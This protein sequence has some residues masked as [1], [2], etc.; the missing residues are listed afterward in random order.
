MTN[1]MIMRSAR[2]LSALALVFAGEQATAGTAVTITFSGVPC[3]SSTGNFSGSFIYDQGQP[4]SGGVFQ[5]VEP[6]KPTDPNYIHQVQYQGDAIVPVVKEGKDCEPFTITLTGQT[7][8]LEA[9]AHDAP[10][11]NQTTKVTIILPTNF[12]FSQTAL[13]LCDHGSHPS[14]VFPN[15]PLAGSK[16]TLSGAVNYEGQITEVTCDPSSS[17]I[18]NMGPPTP[19]PTYIYVYIYAAPSPYAAHNAPSSRRCYRRPCW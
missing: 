7:F 12:T 16:F 15:P 10:T 9:T 13:P 8:K 19:E 2:V 1:S 4:G 14:P 17:A 6:S 5:F 11:N 3:G 18:Q